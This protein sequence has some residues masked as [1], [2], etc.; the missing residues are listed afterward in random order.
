[1]TNRNVK[2][3]S[4]EQEDI[5]KLEKENAFLRSQLNEID[6]NSERVVNIIGMGYSAMRAPYGQGERWGVNCAYHY[7]PM[8][9]S[10]WLHKAELIPQSL[11]MSRADSIT[12]SQVFEMFPDMEIYT[13]D[14]FSFEK[15]PEQIPG[16]P[17][18]IINQNIKEP[19]G[20]VLK[21]TTAYPI[22]EYDMLMRCH[23]G[24]STIMYMIGLAIIMQFQRIRLYGLEVFSGVSASEYHFEKQGIEHLIF[25]AEGRGITVEIPFCSLVTASNKT[26]NRYGFL[27]A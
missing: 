2:K 22:Q 13:L 3:V 25:M 16:Q 14:A 17:D 15:N 11:R 5:E 23:Y 6:E 9:R 20:E 21:V 18:L 27:D 8:D 10:F 26:N 7:G 24:T 1:M 19:I 4:K 12:I